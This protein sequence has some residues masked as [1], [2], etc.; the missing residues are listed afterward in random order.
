MF[1]GRERKERGKG[2]RQIGVN[3]LG[4]ESSDTMVEELEESWREISHLNYII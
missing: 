4:Y 3:N 1:V 2:E